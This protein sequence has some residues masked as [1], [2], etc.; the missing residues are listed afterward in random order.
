MSRGLGCNPRPLR[1]PLAPPRALELRPHAGGPPSQCR[2]TR[3][4]RPVRAWCV[5]AHCICPCICPCVCPCVRP[6]VRRR[7]CPPCICP[8]CVPASVPAL[9]SSAGRAPARLGPGP[10]PAA[11]QPGL[12]RAGGSR[13][14]AARCPGRGRISAAAAATRSSAT[15]APSAR[16]RSFAKPG[17]DHQGAMGNKHST[18]YAG[19]L[20][21]YS[22][23]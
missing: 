20:Q 7:I 4:P 1:S 6:C 13:G 12:P 8:R 17:A 18:V 16:A 2:C 23:S 3:R 22:Y 21:F 5:H 9:T 19:R 10:G 15:S 14:G 11:S